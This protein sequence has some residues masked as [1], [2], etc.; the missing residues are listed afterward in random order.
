MGD[1]WGAIFARIGRLWY[2]ALMTHR[3]KII[4]VYG[5]WLIDL[6]CIAAAF[7][8]ATYIR[9][10]G[11]RGME[12]TAIHYQVGALF[13]VFCTV[14]NFILD[15][16]H[17]FLKRRFKREAAAI[18]QYMAFMLLIASGLMLLLKWADIFS[19]LILIYFAILNFAITLLAHMLMKK[20]LRRYYSSEKAAT[21]LLLIAEEERLSDGI[22][23]LEKDLEAHYQ[24]A[25]AA[26]LDAERTGESIL[27]VPIVAGPSDLHDIASQMALD[28]VFIDAPGTTQTQIRELIRGFDEMGVNCH[29]NIPLSD[30][31]LHK[32]KIE[33]F[34]DSYTVVTYTPLLQSHKRL[35]IKRFMDILGGLVGS[36]VTLLLLPFV[37]LAIRIESAGP[38]FFSQ[39][40]I[41][42]NGRRFKIH[43]FR[44][45]YEDAESK[46]KE[47]ESR[48]E[49]DG[50]MFKI[51]D[52]P[53]ITKVGKFL[54]RFSI[55]ELP[56]FFNILKGDMSLVGT[57][58][59]TVDEFEQYNHYYRRRLSMTPGLS[60]LWQISGRS[61]IDNFDDVVKYD[62]Q[63][64]DEWTLWLDI[65][66]LFKT[67][68]VVFTGKGSK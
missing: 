52:D 13:L 41:G 15:W 3:G 39:V 43:K 57:R 61:D 67:V 53:R 37:A 35:L 7:L 12:D 26:C 22:A 1:L 34:A 23:R 11:F 58:P 48:N 62:L 66:I 50:L 38:V 54:R 4:E 8:L 28:E 64:I 63:Y 49:M 24:L 65:K 60:G 44:S 30:R 32:Q 55:D 36:A 5:L 42:R 16:N 19:R 6:T 51:E 2:N 27:G 47:L 20:A 68:A 56:Q 25:G 14:Y 45:M 17:D 40:R 10:P 18:F 31:G 29:L 46:K 21:Q 59:P 33:K 9:H